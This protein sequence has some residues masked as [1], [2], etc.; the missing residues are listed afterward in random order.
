MTRVIRLKWSSPRTRD[1]HTCCRAFWQLWSCHYLFLRLRSV[2]TGAPRMRGECSTSTPL[3]WY[4]W[5]NSVVIKY[6]CKEHH[7]I[8]NVKLW[9]KTEKNT[10]YIHHGYNI[11]LVDLPC[12]CNLE[13]CKQNRLGKSLS[14]KKAFVIGNVKYEIFRN[15]LREYLFTVLNMVWTKLEFQNVFSIYRRDVG[16]LQILM[17]THSYFGN[18]QT[19]LFSCYH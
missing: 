7:L 14:A 13:N 1:T 18:F 15:K 17:W 10:M 12:C 4:L 2:A 16:S 11:S 8:K 5:T 19:Y 9:Y 6:I 3:R